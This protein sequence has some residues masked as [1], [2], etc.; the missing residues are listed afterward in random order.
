MTWQLGVYGDRSGD[1][2]NKLSFKSAI[3]LRIA[4]SAPLV[5]LKQIV[6]L[7]GGPRGKQAPSLKLPA[8]QFFNG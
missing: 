3:H 2:P 5:L 6:I 8:W 1:L 7:S 4:T